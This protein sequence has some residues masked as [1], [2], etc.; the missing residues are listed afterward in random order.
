[1]HVL[2][3][4]S[5]RLVV[6]EAGLR[7]GFLRLCYRRVC[8]CFFIQVNVAPLCFEW[9]RVCGDSYACTFHAKPPITQNP[10]YLVGL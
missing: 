4:G 6:Y 7:S 1:M 5:Y 3:P 9:L 2:G 8:T 10:M